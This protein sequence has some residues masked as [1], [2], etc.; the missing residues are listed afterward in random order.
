MFAQKSANFL[1]SKYFGD[2]AQ[3]FGRGATLLI[4]KQF[5]LPDKSD[6][7]CLEMQLRGWRVCQW[8]KKLKKFAKIV[9]TKTV[10]KRMGGGKKS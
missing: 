5:R 8:T 10:P 7:I 1:V 9:Q 3:I 2:L 6:L 4:K